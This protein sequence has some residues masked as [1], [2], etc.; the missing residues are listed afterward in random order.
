MKVYSNLH[1]TTIEIPA[2]VEEVMFTGCTGILVP[3]ANVKMNI[4]GCSGMLILNPAAPIEIEETTDSIIRNPQITGGP[5]NIEAYKCTNVAIEGGILNDPDW[6]VN[7]P[8]DPECHNVLFNGCVGCVVSGTLMTGT[9][10][11]G[12]AL[13]FFNSKKCIAKNC[14]VKGPIAKF[15]TGAIIDGPKGSHNQFLGLVIESMA[16]INICG[17]PGHIVKD[18]RCPLAVAVTGEHYKGAVVT[19]PRLYRVIAP[20]L[21]VHAPTVKKLILKACSFGWI[22]KGT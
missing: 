4:N 22:N 19:R 21:Y 10:L 3:N 12:D 9:R 16:N 8:T 14:V 5:H 2:S 7:D 13:N 20:E 6:I 18:C 17:G 15:G 11:R 1:N